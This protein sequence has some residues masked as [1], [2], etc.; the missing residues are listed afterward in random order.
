MKFSF[1]KCFYF[2]TFLSRSQ[3]KN[4]LLTIYQNSYH[5]VDNFTKF[6]SMEHIIPQSFMVDKKNRNEMHNIILIPTKLN[7]ARANFKFVD[8]IPENVP[9]TFLNEYGEKTKKRTTTSSVKCKELKLFSPAEEY[10]GMIAR[11]VLFFVFYH[12]NESQPI[13][14]NKVIDKETVLQWNQ[15]YPPTPFEYYKNKCIQRLQGN[16]NIFI[17]HYNQTKSIHALL[18]IYK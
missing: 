9:T 12:V 2:V 13:I 7:N 1:F 6:E 14:F 4:N 3:L 16:D 18:K 5:S 15:N 10:R 8:Q 11:A 17:S